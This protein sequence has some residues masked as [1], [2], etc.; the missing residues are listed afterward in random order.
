M[1]FSHF[2]A[3]NVAAG[4]ALGDDRLVAFR[5]DNCSVTVFETKGSSL[6][7]VEKGREAETKVN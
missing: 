3:I 1:I 2:I 6:S 4:A 5:P 7:L